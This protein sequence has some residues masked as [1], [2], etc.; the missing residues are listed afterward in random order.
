MSDFKMEPK[1]W[2]ALER[3]RDGVRLS[4]L[5]PNEKLTETFAARDLWFRTRFVEVGDGGFLLSVEG[6]N[7]LAE[8]G[9]PTERQKVAS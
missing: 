9:L 7:A 8:Q 4:D 1:H 6:R 5:P 2:R 3:I